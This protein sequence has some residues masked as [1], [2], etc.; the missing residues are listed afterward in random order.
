MT[1]KTKFNIGDPVFFIDHDKITSGIITNIGQTG[2]T[3]R[4]GTD[5]KY[6]DYIKKELVFKTKEELIESLFN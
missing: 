5:L 2:Y 4:F 1:I 3:L 6:E